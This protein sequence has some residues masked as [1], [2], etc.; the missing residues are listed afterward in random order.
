MD[1]LELFII[2]YKDFSKYAEIGI[3]NECII[4]RNFPMIYLISPDLHLYA[5]ERLGRNNN[6]V[7]QFDDINMLKHRLQKLLC[8]KEN[9]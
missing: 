5:F 4:I 8:N 7:I 3:K 6:E 9:E 1:I 2:L